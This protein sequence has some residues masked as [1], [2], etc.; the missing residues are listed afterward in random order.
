MGSD[1]GLL[2]TDEI[3]WAERAAR[4]LA[5]ICERVMYSIR[6]E[7]Q[8]AYAAAIAS[9]HFVVDADR[10][11][12][13]GP[14]GGLLSVHELFPEDNILLLACDMVLVEAEDLQRLLQL[15]GEVRAYRTG[16]LFEPLC[17]FYSATAL[18][19]IATLYGEQRVSSSLQ[20][21]LRLPAMRVNAVAPQNPDRLRS[22][23]APAPSGSA[24]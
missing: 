17:A 19:E 2:V 23:N 21:I 16:D 7:Q 1:K 24:P 12:G 11:R 15:S 3:T 18:A 4:R 14:L 13:I 6:P 8:S 5:A 10:Y 9:A 20:K 22:Q